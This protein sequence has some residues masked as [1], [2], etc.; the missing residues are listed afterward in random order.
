RDGRTFGPWLL[1]IVRREG[2]RAKQKRIRRSEVAEPCDTFAADEGWWT[3]FQDI[4]PTL[5]QL[6]D[7][8]RL[9]VSLRFIDGLSVREIADATRRPIGTVTKQLSRAIKRLRGF[10][11]EVEK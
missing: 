4:L 5:E 8:E 1:S 10:I 6:P 7:Q 9:V 2:I 3:E 11:T